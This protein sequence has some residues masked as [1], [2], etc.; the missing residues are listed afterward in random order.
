MLFAQNNVI[1]FSSKRHQ[2]HQNCCL[3]KSY[4]YFKNA[5]NTHQRSYISYIFGNHTQREKLC[6]K[7]LSYQQTITSFR[8]SVQQPTLCGFLLT[9][10]LGLTS[11]RM[12]LYCT[13][14]WNDKQNCVSAPVVT[15][16][17]Q[18]SQS[19]ML[20]AF[21]Q[22]SLPVWRWGN[23]THQ[24][25]WPVAQLHRLNPSSEF[26]ISSCQCQK[27]W[28]YQKKTNVYQLLSHDQ[29]INNHHSCSCKQMAGSYTQDGVV[30]IIP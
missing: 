30:D 19:C 1:N 3:N 8:Q 23:S 18:K 11:A 6:H 22:G 25:T 27:T 14:R 26:R 15:W 17:I 28:L 21:P 16:P 7:A 20:S 10:W 13:H 4:F 12:T 2:C 9:L 5:P 29:R 24:K